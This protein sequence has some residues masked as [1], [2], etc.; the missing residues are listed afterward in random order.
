MPHGQKVG[1]VMEYEWD[2]MVWQ[3]MS[4][5]GANFMQ[6]GLYLG[7]HREW[8]YGGQ[9]EVGSEHLGDLWLSHSHSK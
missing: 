9:T 5:L 1:G 2:R 8:L 3:S 6:V 7:Y 4:N